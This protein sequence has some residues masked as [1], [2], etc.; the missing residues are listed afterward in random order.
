MLPNRQNFRCDNLWKSIIM[1]L[2]KPGKLRDFFS[3]FVA[4]LNYVSDYMFGGR[5]IALSCPVCVVYIKLVTACSELR[6]VLFLVLWLF[7]LCMK[8][9][10]NCWGTDLHQIH[11]EDMF[12][13]SLR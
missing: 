1:A 7:C 9:V 13:P 4:S 10:W 8:Y 5:K 6:M 12:C 3:Y 11:M 2:E